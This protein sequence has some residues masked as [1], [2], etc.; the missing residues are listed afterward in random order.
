MNTNDNILGFE[1]F[2]FYQCLIQW[3]IG[4]QQNTTLHII[5]SKHASA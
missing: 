3:L 2:K 1:E 4:W 5:S